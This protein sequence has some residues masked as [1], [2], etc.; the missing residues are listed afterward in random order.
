M[1]RGIAIR[2]RPPHFY[3]RQTRRAAV[4]LYCKQSIRLNEGNNALSS[5]NE[6]GARID[7]DYQPADWNHREICLGSDYPAL[8]LAFT[9]PDGTRLPIG[10]N[11]YYPE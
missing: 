6:D 3:V 7:W 2:P 5:H 9:F 10:H 4:C 11:G 1:P 8:P